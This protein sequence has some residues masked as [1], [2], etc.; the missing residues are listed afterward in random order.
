M[1]RAPPRRPNATSR[2][3]AMAA[4]FVG[5]ANVRARMKC[6]EEDFRQYCDGQKEPTWPELDKLVGLI[7]EQQRLL[8]AR[9]REFLARM[10]A[11]NKL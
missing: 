6:S 2:L 10:R 11:K 8:I 4:S 7:I 9:N 5:A 3:I 1:D